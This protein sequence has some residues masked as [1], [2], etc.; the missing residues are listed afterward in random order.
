M[1]TKERHRYLVHNPTLYRSTLFSYNTISY[2]YFTNQI[3]PQLSI[4]PQLIILQ[5]YNDCYI[6][7]TNTQY[8]YL[9]IIGHM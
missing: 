4:T 8:I 1:F 2:I 5:C 7:N 6:Q 9:S 3:H